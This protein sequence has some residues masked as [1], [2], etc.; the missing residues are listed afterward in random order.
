[1]TWLA[2]GISLVAG[3]VGWTCTRWIDDDFAM[4]VG[5]SVVPVTW[6]V[7][8]TLA[9]RETASERA[10]RIQGTSGDALACPTCGYN[11]TGLRGTRCPECGTDF[12][13]QELLSATRERA[14]TELL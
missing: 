13:L 11:L 12:T 7:G 10:Q 4:F 1:M 14:G 3:V 8:T 9:W 6:L 2:T 5:T